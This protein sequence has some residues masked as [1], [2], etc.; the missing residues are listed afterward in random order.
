MTYEG[1]S[2]KVSIFSRKKGIE[3]ASTNSKTQKGCVGPSRTKKTAKSFILLKSSGCD[4][5]DFNIERYS[6]P[7]K[8]FNFDSTK[9]SSDD[10]FLMKK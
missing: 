8:L 2:E 6:C 1:C 3:P 9:V 5:L 4:L 10:C 7:V